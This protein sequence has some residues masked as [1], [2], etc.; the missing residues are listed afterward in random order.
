MRGKA[1][2]CS[3]SLVQV[4][5]QDA[6][7]DNSV[8]TQNLT[9]LNMTEVQVLYTTVIKAGKV[10]RQPLVHTLTQARPQNMLMDFSC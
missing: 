3:R 2:P 9:V 8:V 5:S 4:R 10:M 1:K 6:H 7:L